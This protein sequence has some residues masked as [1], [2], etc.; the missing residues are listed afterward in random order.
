MVFTMFD[1]SDHSIAECS[2]LT[3]Q[4]LSLL[5]K[6]KREREREKRKER[7]KGKGKGENEKRKRK[8]RERKRSFFLIPIKYWAIIKKILLSSESIFMS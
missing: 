8:K 7:G 2:A 4:Q 1:H 5:R 3:V 6:R